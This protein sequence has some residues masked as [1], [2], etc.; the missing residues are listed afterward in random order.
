MKKFQN[1]E[2]GL[3]SPLEILHN[4]FSLLQRTTLNSVDLCRGHRIVKCRSKSLGHSACSKNMLKT[5]TM[6]GLTLTAV[7]AAEKSLT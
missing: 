7:T 6:Q 2:A 3:I 4:Q 5:N 1:L